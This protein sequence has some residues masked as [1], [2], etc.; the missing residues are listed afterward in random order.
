VTE[1]APLLPEPMPLEARAKLGVYI[2]ALRDPRTKAVFYVGK[3]T[4]DRI[5]HHV[6]D[7]LGEQQKINVADRAGKGDDQAT[8]K[9]KRAH[10]RELYDAGLLPEHWVLRHG[11]PGHGDPHAE[12]YALEQVAID[13]A[14]L[15]GQ[16]LTNIAGGHVETEHG[17]HPVKELIC[18]T[19][20]RPRRRCPGR[21]RS[22]S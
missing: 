14:T 21:V 2:Y 11:V 20:R 22:S 9:T 8:T 10:I 7:A 3:G 1:A 19:P 5:Y 17:M 12:A 13:L 15:A 16:P 18:A 6:W 4:G